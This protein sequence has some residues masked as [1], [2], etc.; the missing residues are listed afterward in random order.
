[1]W[2]SWHVGAAAVSGIAF[3]C[4]SAFRT[5]CFE[6]EYISHCGWSNPMWQVWH[7]SGRS[8]SAFANRWRVWHASQD[9]TP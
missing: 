3:C 4:R 9:A 1:M 2:Q 7:A 6:P 5:P 8:A